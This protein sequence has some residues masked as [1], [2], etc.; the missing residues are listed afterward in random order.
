MSG[1]TAPRWFSA[2]PHKAW[3]ERCFLLYAPI[4]MAVMG[5]VMAFGIDRRLGDPGFIL[6]GLLVA[7]PY[8]L[9]PALRSPEN[10]TTP[11]HR[12][13]WF[14]AN[15]YIFIFGFFGNYFGTEYFFDVLGMVYHYP[16]IDWTLDAR[17]GNSSCVF[18]NVR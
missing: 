16:A 6:L 13:Y 5:L 7:L 12:T 9:I 1:P 2:N 18:G 3:A 10:A 11:W 14:K 4:W 15:V 17:I 8:A